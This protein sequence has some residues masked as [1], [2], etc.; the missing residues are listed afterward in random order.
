MLPFVFDDG[1]GYERYCDY[2]LD[3]PMYFV[4]RD[5]QY[6]DAAGLSFRDFLDGRL[7]ALPG[8]KPTLADWTDHLSTAFPEVRLKSFLEMRGAD[9][10]RWG[11]SARFRHCG[12][13]C[14]IRAPRLMRHGIASSIG[15]SR[16]A[17]RCAT[18]CR[19]RR[20]TRPCLVALPCASLPPKCSKLRPQGFESAR[21]IMPPAIARTAFSTRSAMSSPRARRSPMSCSIAITAPG[22][23]RLRRLFGL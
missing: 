16:S 22:M 19:A 9:G 2:A 23:R 11:G 7:S 5:G 18:R 17:R 21:N 4:F 1:F 14:F 12:S 10:G 13:A 15:R 3:V 8:E 6:I 20:S